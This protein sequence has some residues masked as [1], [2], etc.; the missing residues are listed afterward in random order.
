MNAALMI[1]IDLNAMAVLVFC[2]YFP[3]H[4]RA[5]LVAATDVILTGGGLKVASGGGA[6]SGMKSDSSAKGVK[7][8]VFL[9]VEGA[10]LDVDSADD[11]LHSKGALRL[12]SGTI[13]VAG[14]GDGVHA[15]VAALLDG[16]DV[17]VAQSNEGLEAGLITISGERSMSRRRM[18]G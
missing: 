12:S 8:G 13:S 3:R 7:A 17:T 14:G 2:L 9:I 15:E 18:T 11:S 5:D 6:S 1:A 16:A 4:R 10:S